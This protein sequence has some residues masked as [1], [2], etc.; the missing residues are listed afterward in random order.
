MVLRYVLT[1]AS[2][3]FTLATVGV[4]FISPQ[5]GHTLAFA[6]FLGASASS[7]STCPFDAGDGSGTVL[8]ARRY[9][10]V[11][12]FHQR[13]DVCGAGGFA[14]LDDVQPVLGTVHAD[15]AHGVGNGLIGVQ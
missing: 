7:S 8:C 5:P 14:P 6:T 4:T 2:S 9:G 13:P 12:L 1:I 15:L 3:A 11:V 10:G